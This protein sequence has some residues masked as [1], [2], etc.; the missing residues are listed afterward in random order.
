M[1]VSADRYANWMPIRMYWESGRPMVDWCY[2]GAAR[3]VDPFFDETVEKVLRRP[4]SLL[5]RRQTSIEALSELQAV[6]PGISPSGFIFHMSR[7]GSTLV[8]QMLAS[9]SRNIVL[10]EAG[11]IDAVLR[12]GFRASSITDDHKIEWLRGIVSALAR[13]R[14]AREERLFIKFDAWHVLHLPLIERAFPG[15]PWIFVYRDPVEVVASHQKQPGAQVMPAALPPPLFGL[16]L[17]GAVSMPQGGYASHVLACICHAALQY[18]SDRGLLV[19]YTQ[20]P[21]GVFSDVLEHF[22]V[23]YVEDDVERMRSAARFDAK[24]PSQVF[25]SDTTAK[26]SALQP[27]VRAV[28]ER[29]V[30]PLYEELEAVRTRRHTPSAARLNA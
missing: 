26:Q 25:T 5:F 14:C 30:M 24:A 9:V 29:A 13:K 4:F 28:V 3:F 17:A 19:N 23:A 8:S 6:D 21:H 11:P 7:C 20:L 1:T 27:H 12:S 15:V 16:A 10:S 2:I 18:R 22:G